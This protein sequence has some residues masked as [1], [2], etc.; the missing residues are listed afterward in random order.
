MAGLQDDRAGE[1]RDLRGRNGH[2][3]CCPAGGGGQRDRDRDGRRPDRRRQERPPPIRESTASCSPSSRRAGMRSTTWRSRPRACS[4]HRARRLAAEP[5]GVRQRD[6]R[7]RLP[8]QRRQRDQSR[9]RILRDA[10]QRQ[11]RRCRGS[12]D[13]RARIEGRVRQLLRRDDRRADQV[14]Q[15]RVPRHRRRATRSSDRRRAINPASNDDL[16]ASWLFVGEGEQL[17]GETKKDWERASRSAGRS[18]RTSCG[19]SA[20]STTSAAPACRRDGRSRASPG[21][22]TPTARSRPLPSRITC[23]WG[24]YHYE[25]ND[26]NGWSW[27]SEPA[28]DTTMTY[29]S[30][31]EEPHGR[32]AVAVVPE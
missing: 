23:V 7:E 28:W 13:R 4:T 11:L 14:R 32:G 18:A 21:A 27:G 6:Q 2:A 25:N 22:A 8:D 1:H 20:R 31:D 30:T 10:R 29:G 12:A 15:Q 26:G 9:G 3:R 17:A 5:H 16:G 19:S 24:S